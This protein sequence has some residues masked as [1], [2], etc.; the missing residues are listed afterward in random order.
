[1]KTTLDLLTAFLKRG[2]RFE[3]DPCELR[4]QE[5]ARVTELG[6]FDVRFLPSALRRPE[7]HD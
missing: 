3:L 4:E 1:M 5:R 7:S 6:T 2:M